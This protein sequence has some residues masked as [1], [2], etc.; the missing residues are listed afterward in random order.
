MERENGDMTCYPESLTVAW[1][2][3]QKKP[4]LEGKPCH[5]TPKPQKTKKELEVKI[6]WY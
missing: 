5:D 6:K 4:K 3:W 2:S 1:S